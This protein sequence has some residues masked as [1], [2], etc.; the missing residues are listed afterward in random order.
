VGADSP[1]PAHTAV[2]CGTAAEGRFAFC[3]LV[4]SYASCPLTPNFRAPQPHAACLPAL[5]Q[6]PSETA[7]T[8]VCTDLQPGPAWLQ[9]LLLLCNQCRR[10]EGERKHCICYKKSNPRFSSGSVGE[11]CYDKYVSETGNPNSNNS[12]TFFR[13]CASKAAHHSTALA[14]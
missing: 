4:G 14:G 10:T 11:L 3:S 1:R 2:P 5:G 6:L 8:G 12:K 7:R 13:R 9:E